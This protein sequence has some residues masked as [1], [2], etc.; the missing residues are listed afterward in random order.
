MRLIADVISLRHLI[1]RDT[2]RK[3][4]KVYAGKRKVDMKEKLE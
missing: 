2:R 1:V 4:P 3:L